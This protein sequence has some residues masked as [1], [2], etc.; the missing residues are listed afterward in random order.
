[1]TGP[2]ARR[3]RRV[4][5]EGFTK[6]VLP[7]VDAFGYW[8]AYEVADLV[9][10][11]ELSGPIW[12]SKTVGA[13]VGALKKGLSEL[14]RWSDDSRRFQHEKWQ[15]R[16]NAFDWL[17]R[18]RT[19]QGI[20][21]GSLT[22]QQA[23][24]EG[25]KR[26]IAVQGIT[27]EQV[28]H[29]I[30]TVFVRVFRETKNRPGLHELARQD[31]FCAADLLTKL[32]GK[33]FDRRDPLWERLGL[34]DDILPFESQVARAHFEQRA[35]TYIQG[36]PSVKGGAY[37]ADRFSA[38]TDRWWMESTQFRRFCRAY[39][40]LHRDLGSGAN[41]ERRVW[42]ADNTPTDYFLLCTLVVEKLLAERHQARARQ[43]G[44]LG[45]SGLIKQSVSHVERDARMSGACT[46]LMSDWG[47]RT[48]LFGLLASPQNPLSPFPEPLNAKDMLVTAF[49][50]FGILRNYFAHHDV[51]D[52][53]LPYTEM[54]HQ[55][56][57]SLL[58]VVV[59]TLEAS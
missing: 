54:G 6:G 17:S 42:L 10:A 20:W 4:R 52:E 44:S 46:E 43:K 37:D 7:W 12:N 47:D 36:F 35:H 39:D 26:F 29:D 21:A 24:R 8:Q 1:M 3:P 27:E 48:A 38:L 57:Q 55:G 15:Q 33:A 31:I 18:Y 2:G 32:P 16:A 45:F 34:F 50:N 53:T 22:E 11:A 23:L 41:E 13:R 49:R 56:M 40:R 28:K 58:L 59:L 51:L 25:T 30:R 19:L 9:D 14:V 5:K